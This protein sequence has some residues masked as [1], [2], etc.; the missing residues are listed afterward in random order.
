MINRDCECASDATGNR[1]C[2]RQCHTAVCCS[3]T[4]ENTQRLSSRG[5]GGVSHKSI[6]CG[7]RRQYRP[8]ASD[9]DRDIGHCT[10][11][12]DDRAGYGDLSARGGC[13]AQERESGDDGVEL[14]WG[15][16]HG[17]VF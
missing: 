14:E 2:N 9:G 15:F 1:V 12:H 3:R 8:V 10:G 5:V 16:F 13:G 6:P 4:R 17:V 7:S 11:I